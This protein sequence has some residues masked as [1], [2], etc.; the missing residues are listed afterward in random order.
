MITCG[1]F[2]SVN[3]DRTYNAEQMNNPYK[4]IISNGVFAKNNGE[5]SDDFK[6]YS[7]G[8]MSVLVNKG[9]GIFDGKWAT[10]DSPFE[11]VVPVAD[12][13]NARIDSIVF[14][15]NYV[16]R[17]G[18][19][20]LIQ[21][22]AN[23]NPIVPTITR[24]DK[25][26]DYRLANIFVS[27][28]A[29]AINNTDITDTR[30]TSDCGFVTHLL[31]QADITTL[32]SQWQAQF[33]N[34]FLNIKETIATT[35]VISSFSSKFIATE[36]TTEVPINVD[37][38]NSV[39]DILQVYKNGLLLIEGYDYTIN[40]FNTITLADSISANTQIAFVVYKSVDGSEAESFIRDMEELMKRV[41]VVENSFDTLESN[42]NTKLNNYES[43]I[44]LVELNFTEVAN[45]LA[46]TTTKV[47]TATTN[48]SN[49]TTKVN[50]NVSDITAL[51][52]RIDALEVNN[53]NTALWDGANTLGSGEEIKP[54]KALSAC[55]N[56][57]LL[58]FCGYNTSTNIATNTRFN[59][60]FINKGVHANIPGN[61]LPLYCNMIA[62]HFE[63]G[64]V[65]YVA[66][67]L[68]VYDDRIEGAVQNT[69]SDLGKSYCLRFV[70]EF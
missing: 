30:A 13:Y 64:N 2:N 24:N 51:D 47:N 62:N 48:I 49:L 70:F 21:G 53:A 20:I 39:L 59:T 42:V 3:G 11:I 44:D 4:R 40:D 50:K 19:I 34:W 28:N 66:K 7:N 25:Y 61:R 56:G 10:N 33:E 58:V 12:V 43:R 23:E 35:T 27:A 15:V 16:D 32:Y 5:Q 17:I 14:R 54:S 1:F 46:T 6:V 57:W 67:S 18:E 8:E 69:I 63:S 65:E 36:N 60:I 37:N 22:R 52:T 9:D 55:K 26:V 41:K 29:V 31:E 38:Y 45:D 68:N